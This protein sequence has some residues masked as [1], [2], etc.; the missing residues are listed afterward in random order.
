MSRLTWGCSLVAVAAISFALGCSDEKAGP[1]AVVGADSGT[2]AVVLAPMCKATFADFNRTTLGARTN[3]A[4][5]C[6]APSDL[7]V[8]CA[9]DVGGTARSC[10]KSCIAV[11][12]D[13][14][15]TSACVKMTINPSV[16]EACLSCYALAFNCTVAKCFGECVA[17]PNS[18]ACL[19]C[20]QANGCLSM[21]YGCS[22]L[23]SAAQ[24]VD[25]G[26]DASLGN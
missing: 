3:P 19:S 9:N 8:I 14:S 20:Q 23:P 5:K 24:T 17:D 15:C 21:F 7:D 26:G 13:A 10:G 25:A 18:P 12:G 22:G 16:S 2:D 1:A 4:G 11:G 6:A